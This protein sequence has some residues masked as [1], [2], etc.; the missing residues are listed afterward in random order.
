MLKLKKTIAA[1]LSAVM[2]LSSGS[3]LLSVTADASTTDT[4]VIEARSY[5]VNSLQA[6]Y[7]GERVDGENLLTD[8]ELTGSEARTLARKF[9]VL[10]V[11]KDIVLTGDTAEETDEALSQWNLDAIGVTAG[12][13]QTEPARRVKIAVID[14]GISYTGD[15]FA[16][17]SINLTEDGN[18]NPLFD[19]ASGHGTAVAGMICAADD[20]IGI[21][22]INPNAA[23]YSAK[24]LDS[25]NKSPLS[26]IL[27]GIYWAIENEVDIINMSFGTDVDSEILHNAVKAA[28]DAGI[29]LIASSGNTAG[30]RVKYPAAYSEVIAVGATDPTGR[31]WADTSV[32][33]E[34]ELLAP[35]EKILTSGFL[36][37]T[38]GTSGTSIAAAQVTGVASLLMQRDATKSAEFI[39]ALLSASAKKVG[40]FG[41]IDY[42]YASEIYNDFADRYEEHDMQTESFANETEPTDYSD[43]A[44]CVVE[45]MWKI[46]SKYGDH[47][48]LADSA[49]SSLGTYYREIITYCCIKVDSYRY[50]KDDENGK[51]V[52]AFHGRGNFVANI[53]FLT[54]F[55]QDIRKGVDVE[56]AI[57]NA[58]K[59]FPNL[60]KK[61]TATNENGEVTYANVP[62]NSNYI[63]YDS[64]DEATNY[65]GNCRKTD[66]KIMIQLID[67]I[68]EICKDL[69]SKKP[70]DC[71]LY[72]HSGI[73]TKRI[74]LVFQGIILHMIGDTYDHRSIVPK[75][76][77]SGLET[78]APK[79]VDG[80]ESRFSESKFTRKAA[81]KKGYSTNAVKRHL[82]VVTPFVYNS[83]LKKLNEHRSWEQFM[84][85]V[86]DQIVE[87][88][89]VAIF[90]RYQYDADLENKKDI[91]KY[92]EFMNGYKVYDDNASFCSERY[93]SAKDC[94]NL[95][96][97]EIGK[98]NVDNYK[99]HI[100]LKVDHLFPTKQCVKLNSFKQYCIAIGYDTGKGTTFYG[101]WKNH[102]VFN[103]V[104]MRG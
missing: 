58:A 55:A 9:S 59:M 50:P 63:Y 61:T 13:E 1:A 86:D 66:G 16:E 98:Q 49:S 67:V 3:Q 56:T 57:S 88:Q 19:D 23:L 81:A 76:T 100:D 97:K 27:Q 68:R 12:G 26:R 53:R 69:F 93:E 85:A 89:S 8:V 39:R 2:L 79:G 48:K 25:E 101:K 38:L 74:Y 65:A 21:T 103:I 77:I 60:I 30:G 5:A 54:R 36:G 95:Y 78:D 70:N 99:K 28:H 29:L 91:S 11:E 18:E 41:L 37:G 46:D 80:Y 17:E 94:C 75:Y 90:E 45:G 4:Y 52:S 40:D 72:K 62:G 24:V 87:F 64:R 47:G 73:G 32:G 104:D 34:L 82:N 31:L 102:S 7:G 22:G 96:F 15:I 6:T 43:S 33:D 35:G 71:I 83:D 20:D 51:K 10:A 14:S 92:E 42:A 44:E 84:N